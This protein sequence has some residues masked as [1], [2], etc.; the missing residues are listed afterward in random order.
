MD[1][2]FRQFEAYAFQ[3]D[4]EFTRG[5]I[6]VFPNTAYDAIPESDLLKAQ[7]FYYSKTIK[8]F[9]WSEYQEWKATE[10]NNEAQTTPQATSTAAAEPGPI[11]ASD[12]APKPQGFADLCEMIMTGQPIPGVRDI[13]DVVSD[14]PASAAALAPRPKPW[15]KH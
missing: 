11:A 4:P 14:Q 7:W 5:L 15:E 13:P 12:E 9:S 6:T 10:L 1:Q 8:P 2:V 3:Q